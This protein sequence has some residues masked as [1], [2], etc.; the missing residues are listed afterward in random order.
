MKRLFVLVSAI[1]VWAQQAQPALAQSHPLAGFCEGGVVITGTRYTRVQL[2]RLAGDHLT[3]E[4]VQAA[5]FTAAVQPEQQ[6]EVRVR[7]TQRLQ[8]NNRW[9]GEIDDGIL[10]SRLDAQGRWF[11]SSHLSCDVSHEKCCQCGYKG[12]P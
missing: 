11:G 6:P 9:R 8:R 7:V 3:P 1:I 5:A 12:A 10:Q 4:L 2:Q